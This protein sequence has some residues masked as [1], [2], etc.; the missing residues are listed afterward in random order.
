MKVYEKTCARI[1][2]CA[3]VHWVLIVAE[4]S[5]PDGELQYPVRALDE[6]EGFLSAAIEGGSVDVDE[7]VAHF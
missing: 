6:D 5:P 2:L 4:C 3:L 7:L 1:T